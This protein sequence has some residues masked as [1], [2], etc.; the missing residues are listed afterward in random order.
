[1][2]KSNFTVKALP[3][4]TNLQ[5]TSIV[6]AQFLVQ[7]NNNKMFDIENKGQGDGAQHPQWLHSIAQIK[8]NKRHCTIFA[9]FKIMTFKLVDVEN[10]GQGH[11]VLHSQ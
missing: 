4:E 6:T 10:L 1:M 8:I 11:G 5:V 9:T 2:N 7:M 3:V